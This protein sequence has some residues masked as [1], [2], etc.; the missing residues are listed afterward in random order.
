MQRHYLHTGHIFASAEP[1]IVTTV[2]G[3]CVSV[4]LWDVENGI[5]GLNHYLLPYRI[6]ETSAN[7]R[8]GSLATVELIER[9]EALGARRRHLRAHIVVGSAILTGRE[10]ASLG[11]LNADLATDMLRDARIAVVSTDVGGTRGRKVT[12]HTG[13]GDMQVRLL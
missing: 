7:S 2:L 5:G 6:G 12:F 8:F 13:S 9:V 1:S 4:C 11:R 10:S 3:S